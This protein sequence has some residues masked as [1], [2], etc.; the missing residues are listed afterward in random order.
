MTQPNTSAP[1]GPLHAGRQRS[2]ARVDQ[3]G[4]GVSTDAA[5]LRDFFDV[6]MANASSQQSEISGCP[7][8]CEAGR[9]FS[10][11]LDAAVVA[12]S[13]GV[14]LR[15][16]QGMARRGD[17]PELLHVMRGVYR[18]RRTDHEAWLA[19]RMTRAEM[20]REELQAERVKAA[21]GGRG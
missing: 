20:A 14:S 9:A 5:G 17:Y 15:T 7:A 19:G 4:V 2:A 11:W 8:G 1:G 3:H 21:V 12:R 18:V 16:L 13:I 6:N 10:S